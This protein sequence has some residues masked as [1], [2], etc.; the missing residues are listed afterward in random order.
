MS[1]ANLASCARNGT[2]VAAPGLLRT[3][4][5]VG[6][7]NWPLLSSMMNCKCGSSIDGESG[8]YR[9]RARCGVRGIKKDKLER[10]LLDSLCEQFFSDEALD[11]LQTEVKRIFDGQKSESYKRS[12]E[13]EKKI[14]DRDKQIQDLASLLTEVSHRRPLI[15]RRKNPGYPRNP[16]IA[17]V[18]SALLRF[19]VS[20]T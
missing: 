11:N 14:K 17:T 16:W 15:Q 12:K 19:S 3:E 13:L 7:R 6:V 5:C 4:D 2:I 20:R 9:C 10:A 8:F 18:L 1:R